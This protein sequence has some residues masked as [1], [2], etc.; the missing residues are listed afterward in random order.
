MGSVL[1]PMVVEQTS[2]GE[3]AYDIYSRLLKENII[4]LGTPI[5][6]QVANLIIAQLLFLEAEDPEKDISIYINSPGGSITAGLAILDTMAFIRPDI[7]TIC[8]GHDGDYLATASQMATQMTPRKAAVPPKTAHCQ[9]SGT[10]RS[11]TMKAGNLAGVGVVASGPGSGDG[12][13]AA[14]GK[15]DG[16]TV[17]GGATWLDAPSDTT[18]AAAHSAS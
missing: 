10:L 17:E 9:V 1:V 7:V 18:V 15:G 4:F 8:V 12:G 5:D 13:R 2:R 14:S 3:R 11:S 6:D 16:P